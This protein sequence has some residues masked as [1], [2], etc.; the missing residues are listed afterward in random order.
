MEHLDAINSQW[1]PGLTD[2]AA[3]QLLS[4]EEPEA[5]RP[6]LVEEDTDLGILWL[7][8]RDM[9]FSAIR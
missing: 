4:S 8:H 5:A 9:S 3:F 1:L 2:L 6:L 7:L